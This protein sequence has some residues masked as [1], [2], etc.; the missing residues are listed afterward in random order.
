[1]AKKKSLLE[2][3]RGNPRGDWNIR[4]I[5]R[6]CGEMGLECQPPKSGSHF[7]VISDYL[8]DILTIPAHRPIK[9]VYVRLPVS[10][11]DAHMLA[12]RKREADGS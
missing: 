8:A 6:L 1:M 11:A 7:K 2:E 9:P 3:M 4:D 12:T 5:E 10:Y